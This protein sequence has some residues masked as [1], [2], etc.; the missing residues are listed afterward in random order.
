MKK[1]IIILIAV[2]VGIFA[3]IGGRMVYSYYTLQQ[4]LTSFTTI[5]E[6]QQFCSE[7]TYECYFTYEN[8]SE[9]EGIKVY[10]VSYLTESKFKEILAD[11]DA[12]LASAGE[13]AVATSEVEDENT[14]DQKLFIKF[15]KNEDVK[16]NK[17]E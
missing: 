3:I 8:D 17:A 6:L 1:K 13:E 15:Q 4:K 10:S 12:I 5:D 14:N 2:L 9:I 11:N 16:F 7:G